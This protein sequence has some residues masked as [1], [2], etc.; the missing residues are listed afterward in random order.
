MSNSRSKII[1]INGS[2]RSDKGFTEIVL[3]KFIEG[4]ESANAHCEVIY[5]SKKKITSCESC[6]RC[7]F[8]TPGMCKYKDDM[9]AIISKMN[10]ADLL[11]FAC[12]VYFDSMS[13][14]M[15]KMIERL[16]PTYGAFFEF[17]NGRTYH[18]KTVKKKQKAITI[19]TASNP[20]R[21]SFISISRIFNRII[22]N[23]GNQLIGEFNF[24]AS[25]LLVTQPE[26]LTGQLEAVTMAGKEFATRGTISEELLVRANGEYIDNPEIAV[27]EMTSMI[28]EIRRIAS[29]THR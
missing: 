2:H 10:E 9:G 26:L 25:H 1:A 28:L 23:M 12:P 3:R 29:K 27:Q 11:V 17:R 18:L 20:E 6:G 24:P 8:E 7:L 13:S 22:D 21:E 16:R 14:N 19:F 4:A 15:K 5:P